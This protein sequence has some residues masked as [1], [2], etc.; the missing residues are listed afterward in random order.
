[1]EYPKLKEVIEVDQGDMVDRLNEKLAEG[2]VLLCIRKYRNNGP[3]EGEWR[4]YAI[5][6]MGLPAE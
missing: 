3:D 5:Y 4:E 2:W 6:V 1:M